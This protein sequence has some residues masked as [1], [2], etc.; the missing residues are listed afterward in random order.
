L[1]HNNGN[2]LHGLF[3][4]ALIIGINFLPV[5]IASVR[6][7]NAR[8][9]ILVVLLLLDCLFVPTA[10]I[11]LLALLTFPAI[12]IAWF[13]CLIWSLN[14]NTRRK[15]QE[16]ADMIAQA[17]RRESEAMQYQRETGRLGIEAVSHALDIKPRR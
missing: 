14:G 16:R 9:A 12:A 5:I 8:N 1:D 10:A 15:D 6:Q 3:L 4:I 7:H 11:G 17:M 2:A 13:A